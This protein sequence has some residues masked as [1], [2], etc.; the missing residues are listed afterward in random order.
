[1]KKTER[2]NIIKWANTLT[3]EELEKEYYNHAYLS[4]GSQAD[5]MY[6][7]GYDMQDVVERQEHEKFIRQKCDLLGQ[8]CEERGIR[9]WE[10]HS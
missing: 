6:D 3:N 2:N 9:L 1:M 8:L 5:R 7:L 10:R 4:L